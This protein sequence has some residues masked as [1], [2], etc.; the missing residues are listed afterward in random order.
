MLHGI[1]IGAQ[2]SMIT[3][4]PS[5]SLSL[6]AMATITNFF[7]DQILII[8][9]HFIKELIIYRKVNPYFKPVKVRKPTS[10]VVIFFFKNYN[11]ACTKV[12]GARIGNA[13]P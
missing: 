9:A 13:K 2:R 5:H 12:F 7:V 6:P 8:P 3:L 1:N 4:T 10:V 11:L